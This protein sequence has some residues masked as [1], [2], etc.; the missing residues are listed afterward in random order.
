MCFCWCYESYSNRARVMKWI[1]FI[2]T[3]NLRIT[4]ESKVC[5]AVKK[6]LVKE[7]LIRGMK[8]NKISILIWEK[9]EIDWKFEVRKG[10]CVLWLNVR[11][12]SH[13]VN[14]FTY[15]VHTLSVLKCHDIFRMLYKLM[16]RCVLIR[17]LICTCATSSVDLSAFPIEE[18]LWLLRDNFVVG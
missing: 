10:G 8:I 16:V 4:T 12:K 9:Q 1:V 5:C 7:T 18:K 15:S 17:R 13:Y 2:N 14:M 6:W 3:G 11:R